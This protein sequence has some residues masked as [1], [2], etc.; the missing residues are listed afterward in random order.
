MEER[1]SDRVIGA[2]EYRLQS[3]IR[4]PKD[5]SIFCW[6]EQAVSDM[7]HTEQEQRTHQILPTCSLRL[8][9][10][11]VSMIDPVIDPSSFITPSPVYLTFPVALL[12]APFA[13]CLLTILPAC[14][15]AAPAALFAFS[16]F[17]LLSAVAFFSLPA[18]MASWR[19]AAR[20]SGRC[21]RRSLITSR[22]APTMP[23][24]CLTVRRVRFLATSCC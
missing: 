17:F 3:V 14:P 23:R 9:P 12:G 11:I 22:E 24:C 6:S 5:V 16:C 7:L 4:D 10:I 1:S 2:D 20:A 21:D 8:S 18:L 15:R 13:P 19:A